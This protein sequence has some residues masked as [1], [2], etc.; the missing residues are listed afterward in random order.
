MA[1]EVLNE[2]WE[3]AFNQQCSAFLPL[4]DIGKNN[5]VHTEKAGIQDGKQNLRKGKEL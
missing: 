2:K 3:R 4:A 5:E 1:K